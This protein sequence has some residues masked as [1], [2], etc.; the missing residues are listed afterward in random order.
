MKLKLN[1]IWLIL[2]IL[3]LSSFALEIPKG[4][5]YDHR[6]RF[7]DYNRN[8]V[9]K[10]VTHYGYLT[11]IEFMDGEKVENIG[12]GD[13][14]A[15][16]VSTS[17]NHL[18]IKPK[19]KDPDTNMTVITNYRV[20]T[21]DV[22]AHRSKQGSQPSDMMFEII[23]QYPDEDVKNAKKIALLESQKIESQK[24]ESALKNT[25]RSVNWNY[26]SKGSKAITPNAVY[27]NDRFTYLTFSNNKEMPAVYIINDDGSESLVNTNIDPND[28]ETII[29]HM[30]AKRLILRKGGSVV[31]IFNKSY[32]MDGISNKTGT[33]S[34]V[35]NRVIKGQSK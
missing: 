15:W 23:F 16:T 22:S 3:P 30:V 35:I 7:I 13:K 25:L 1:I 9:I 33:I 11:H 32:N 26:W 12:M 8:E 31:C 29:V 18:F 2:S 20:Y 6:I 17:N 27:D 5:A 24:V 14:E 4:G 34:P 10:L 21:F 28:K 19:A